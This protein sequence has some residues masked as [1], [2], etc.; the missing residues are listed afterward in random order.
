[1]GGIA[2]IPVRVVFSDGIIKVIHQVTV[3]GFSSDHSG[4]RSLLI[5]RSTQLM[6]SSL[7][8]HD[9]SHIYPPAL[10]PLQFFDRESL[11]PSN[12][13]SEQ[14]IS[15]NFTIWLTPLRNGSLAEEETSE[16]CPSRR[17]CGDDPC[18]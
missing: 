16:F 1:M 7:R 11:P 6:P 9:R 4:S 15:K 2:L 5:S 10:S 3:L 14:S 18:P 8:F 17:G 12:T 13:N